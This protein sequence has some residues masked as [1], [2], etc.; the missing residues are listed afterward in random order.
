VTDTTASNALFLADNAD[1]FFPAILARAD[2]GTRRIY[3]GGS[4]GSPDAAA[5]GAPQESS[6]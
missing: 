3:E 1:F 4:L 5:T 6:P 2:G